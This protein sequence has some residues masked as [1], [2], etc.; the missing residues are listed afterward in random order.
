MHNELEGLDVK[1]DER[2]QDLVGRGRAGTVEDDEEDPAARKRREVNDK[3]LAR[4]R[5]A[6]SRGGGDLAQLA[7]QCYRSLLG[8]H[9]TKVGNLGM[10]RARMVE[11]VNSLAVQMGF[12]EGRLPRISPKVAMTL[13]L[14]GVPGLNVGSDGGGRGGGRHGGGGGNYGRGG[15]GGGRHD[16]YS[17][18]R[19]G[20]SGNRERRG[21]GDDNGYHREDIHEGNYSEWGQGGGSR[22][23]NGGNR[24]YSRS[25]RRQSNHG[26]GFDQRWETY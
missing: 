22:G 21:R 10:N 16:N 23:G 9:A 20:S 3:R 11:H 14:G 7:S 2:C 24:G 15:G 19:Y 1:L 5:D 8:Y 4:V 25:G 18:G 17:R 13:K 26:Q 12:E 6:V